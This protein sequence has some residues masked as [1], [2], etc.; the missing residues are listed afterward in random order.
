MSVCDVI[1]IVVSVVTIYNYLIAIDILDAWGENL[2]IKMSPRIQLAKTRCFTIP[3][4]TTPGMMFVK[5]SYL[6]MT[7]ETTVKVNK[8]TDTENKLIV[9]RNSPFIYKRISAVHKHDICHIIHSS[10]GTSE[11]HTGHAAM[12]NS[13]KVGRFQFKIPIS[14]K[15]MI[16]SK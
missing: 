6:F 5:K 16:Q 2:C 13:S 10:S 7:Y 4:K 3:I 14:L 12:F 9:Y 1:A 15:H 8:H 11:Q